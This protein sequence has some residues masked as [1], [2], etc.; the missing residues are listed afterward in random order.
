MQEIKKLVENWSEKNSCSKEQFQSL[1]GS[2]LFIT[3]CVKHARFFLNRLLQILGDHHSKKIITLTDQSHRDISWFKNF[4]SKFNGESF[5]VKDKRDKQINLDGGAVYDNQNYAGKIPEKF[6][7]L[8]ISSL[9]MLNIPVALTVWAPMWQGTEIKIHCD[10]SAVVSV[11]NNG[12]TKDTE[13]VAIARNIFIVFAQFDIH[14]HLCTEIQGAK[15]SIAELL[16]R[17]TVAIL[18]KLS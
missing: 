4:I 11:L 8:H 14:V 1:L 9:E 5:Y 2:L 13:L 12:K 18:Q 7:D 3:K 15:N 17:W 6:R 10:I 16:S